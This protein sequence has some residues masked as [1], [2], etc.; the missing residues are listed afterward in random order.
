MIQSPIAKASDDK[1]MNV[2]LDGLVDI[3]VL[4]R[5]IDKTPIEELELMVGGKIMTGAV[6]GL[7]KAWKDVEMSNVDV[8]EIIYR[9]AF[10]ER[11]VEKESE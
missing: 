8:L 3:L 1:V 9:L 2:N 11:E 5:R 7:L 10:A 4:L 6:I